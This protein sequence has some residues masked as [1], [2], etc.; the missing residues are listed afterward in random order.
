MYHDLIAG[1]NIEA[2][3]IFGYLS[4]EGKNLGVSTPVTNFI[5]AFLKPHIS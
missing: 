5:Y 4:N 1:K 2:E 3:D